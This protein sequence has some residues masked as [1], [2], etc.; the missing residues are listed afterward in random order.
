MSKSEGLW[1]YFGKN[2]P[3]FAVNSISEMRTETSIRTSSALFRGRRSV[4]RENLE[5]IEE[6]FVP[7]F[8]PRRALDFG[9]GVGR[10]TIPIARRSGQTV[11]VDISAKM[12]EVAEQNARNFEL[13]NLQFIKGDDRILKVTGEFR[14][15]PLIYRFFQHIKPTIGEP[16]FRR[17]IEMLVEGGIGV[18]QFTYANSVSTS[19]QKFRSKLTATCLLPTRRATLCGAPKANRLFL[20][21]RILSTA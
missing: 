20:C 1:E 7:H 15:Y 12:L 3:Y 21:I 4:C 17:M 6:H 14:F 9:C 5:E 10:L 16:I 2:D 11:G 18:V 8:R 19:A 13:D